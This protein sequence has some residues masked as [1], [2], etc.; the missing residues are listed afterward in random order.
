MPMT[1]LDG[2]Q[3]AVDRAMQPALRE[4]A[5]EALWASFHENELTTTDVD[6]LV[7]AVFVLDETADELWCGLTD[8]IAQA[9]RRGDALVIE[10]ERVAVARF[11][12][13]ADDVLR[14]LAEAVSEQV[15]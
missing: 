1:D 2:L 3:E 11:A 5:E 7:E 4:A 10:D 15:V 6:V 13:V 12:E 8:Q 9:A 14:Q